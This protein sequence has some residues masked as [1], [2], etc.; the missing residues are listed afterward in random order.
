MT[1]IAPSGRTPKGFL[2]I[3][4]EGRFQGGMK[5]SS[6]GNLGKV[7][8]KPLFRLAAALLGGFAGGILGSRQPRTDE[9][10]GT[11]QVVRARPSSSLTKRGRS[12]RTGVSIRTITG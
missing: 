5:A 3:S 9:R 2:S 7:R 10:P 6:S 12:F 8:M 11:E 1:S 4:L